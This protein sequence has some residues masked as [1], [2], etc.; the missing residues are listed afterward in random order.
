MVMAYQLYRPLYRQLVE[1][2]RN[3]KTRQTVPP[4]L[5]LEKLLLLLLIIH[6][7]LLVIISMKP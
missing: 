1:N 4:S 6:I 5:I 2:M 3:A 7:L